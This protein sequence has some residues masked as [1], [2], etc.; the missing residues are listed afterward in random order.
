MPNEQEQKHLS[1]RLRVKLAV[2]ILILSVLGLHLFLKT[3]RVDGAAALLLG[4]AIL[5]WLSDLLDT[6]ELP[7]GWKFHFRN[8]AEEQTKQ[9]RQLEQL[10]LAFRLLLTDAELQ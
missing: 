1:L 2:S 7:G 5:P 8:I 10:A 4:L 9:R 3:D 6:L